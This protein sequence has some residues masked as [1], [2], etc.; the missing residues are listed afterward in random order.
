M[1][2]LEFS[3]M[4]L[5]SLSSEEITT[6]EGGRIPWKKIWDGTKWLAEKAGII[7]FCAD[8]KNGFIEGYKE[9]RK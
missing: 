7:D 9:A 3:K 8:V 5:I 6:I 1:Q 4:G 2:T